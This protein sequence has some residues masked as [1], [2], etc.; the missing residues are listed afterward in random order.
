MSKEQFDKITELLEE[1][2]KWTRLEGTQ[3]AK[4]TLTELLKTDN[5]KAI[6]ENSD[7][8]KT[9]REIAA[10]IGVSHVTVINYWKRWS[11]YGIVKEVSARGGT[12][13]KK[14]FSLS[15][16]GIERK[17]ARAMTKEEYV[18]EK[19]G[20]RDSKSTEANQV[21]GGE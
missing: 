13:F 3:K 12:R 19:E 21:S 14:V 16:F 5:E 2:L 20:S 18:E 11:R 4:A 6:Y 10:I 17:H 1:I 9:S 7:G 8:K 15:D